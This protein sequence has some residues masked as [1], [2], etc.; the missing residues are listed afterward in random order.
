MAKFKD[1][2]VRKQPL[3]VL[4]SSDIEGTAGIAHWDETDHVRG[5]KWYDYFC[6][7]MTAEVA[8][9]CRGAARAGAE[10]IL[11]KDAHD[12]ARNINPAGLPQGVQLNR[13]WNGGLFEMVAG[14]SADFD[15]VCFTGYHSPGGSGGNPLSH[16]MTLQVDEITING[17]RASEFTLAAYTAGMLGVPTPFVSG[18]AAL[19]REA[20]LLVPHITAVAVSAGEGNASTSC[21]PKDACQMIESG[22]EQALSQDLQKC[23][24]E[25]PANFEVKIR[26][27]NHHRAYAM[28]L[29]PGAGQLDEKTIRFAHGDYYEV[30][31]FFHFVLV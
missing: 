10:H 4:I 1:G 13:G 5:G 27:K 18:D 8:A 22:M 21:H 17:R 14:L 11:V 2:A 6:A 28:A 15:A 31:R 26:Y 20:K 3:K 25:M 7:Q 29:Y 19:C 16:T 23:L 12:T 24:V 30:L 9:A